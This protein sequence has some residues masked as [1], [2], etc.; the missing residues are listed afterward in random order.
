MAIEPP[1]ET[2]PSMEDIEGVSGP[3]YQC[4]FPNCGSKQY[5]M[6]SS[7]KKHYLIHTKPI[8]CEISLCPRAVQ[9]NGY[10]TNN[11]MQQHCWVSH[12]AHAIA[13]GFP[14][15]EAECGLCGKILTKKANLPR[16]QER[17]CPARPRKVDS[18]KEAGT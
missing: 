18:T 15:P 7:L 12:R 9:G 3:P 5:G 1:A 16:H 14:K 10:A 11:D 4:P 8:L 2:S 6:K 13:R 17:S